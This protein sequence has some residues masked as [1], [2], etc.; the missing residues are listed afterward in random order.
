MQGKDLPSIRSKLEKLI[1]TSNTFVKHKEVICMKE[2]TIKEGLKLMELVED[3]L[4][5]CI[6]EVKAIT[7]FLENILK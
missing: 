5:T 7:I 1:T 4:S 2:K 3:E 6:A